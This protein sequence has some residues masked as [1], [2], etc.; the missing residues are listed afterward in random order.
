MPG[1]T[2]KYDQ[3]L[4]QKVLIQG[5]SWRFES[6]S[7]SH[8]LKHVYPNSPFLALSFG[9]AAEAASGIFWEFESRLLLT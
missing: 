5:G 6:D 8:L 2:G 1:T 4:F 3:W 7:Y 9:R